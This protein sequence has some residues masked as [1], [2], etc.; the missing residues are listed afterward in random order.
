ML[1]QDH[2]ETPQN[3]RLLHHPTYQIRITWIV[4]NDHRP[5]ELALR[6]LSSQR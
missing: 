5:S 3:L 1:P 4:Y 2:K 6:H